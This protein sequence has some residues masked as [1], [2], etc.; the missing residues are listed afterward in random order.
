GEKIYTSKACNACHD[1]TGKKQK[2]GGDLKNITKI[3]DL[4]WLFDFIKNPKSMLKTDGLAKQLLKEFN[5]IPM[6]QQG[7]IDEEVIAIIEFLKAPKKI[8]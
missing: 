1:I 5:N 3:R 7:L 8:K 4:K 2:M 6:P